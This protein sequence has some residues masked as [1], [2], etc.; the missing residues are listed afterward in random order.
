MD[1]HKNNKFKIAKPKLM[2][3]EISRDGGL[4]FPFDQ[5]VIVPDF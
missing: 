4:V 1:K 2:E 3:V 5:P